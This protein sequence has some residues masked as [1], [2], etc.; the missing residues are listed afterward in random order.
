V[1]VTVVVVPVVLVTVV[2]VPVVVDVGEDDSSSATPVQPLI[3][4]QTQTVI[5][6]STDIRI[7]R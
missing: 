5:T 3:T 7:S 6:L 2:V 1:L 4:I